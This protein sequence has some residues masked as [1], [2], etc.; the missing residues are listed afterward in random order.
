MIDAQ[1]DQQ[2]KDKRVIGAK[3]TNGEAGLLTKL[4]TAVQ[5]IQS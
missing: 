3:G 2:N 4:L 1:V 5:M